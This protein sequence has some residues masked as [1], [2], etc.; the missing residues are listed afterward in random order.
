M[1]ADIL[2]AA[3]ELLLEEDPHNPELL[4]MKRLLTEAQP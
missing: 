4:E 2:L 1:E 3:V